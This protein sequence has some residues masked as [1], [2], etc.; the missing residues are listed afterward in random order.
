MTSSR[1]FTTSKISSCTKSRR[2]LYESAAQQRILLGFFYFFPAAGARGFENCVT[3]I[4]GVQSV[5]ERW[6][7]WLFLLQALDEVRDLVDKGVFVADL[8]TGHPPVLHIRML[9]IR[10]MH[11]LPTAD[12]LVVL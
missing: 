12:Q 4:L 11:R 1:S 6:G 8:Q 2:R 9:A 3:D 5:A 7:N 10:D